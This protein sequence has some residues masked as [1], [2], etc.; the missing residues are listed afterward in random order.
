LP[1]ILARFWPCCRRSPT[2]D[3]VVS[4]IEPTFAATT[5]LRGALTFD[6][7]EGIDRNT[8]L[9]RRFAGG[10][11]K[12]VAARSPRNLGRHTARILIVDEAD[13]CETTPEGNP[14]RLAEKRTLSFPNRKIIIGST[15]LLEETSHVLRSYAASD[16]RIFECPCPS[17][18]AFA[19]LLW[20]AIEWPE[21]R[22]E[23]AAWRCP[24]CAEL[25]AERHK[26][27]MVTAGAWRA[28]REANGHAGF[29]CSA[30]ISL[31]GNASWGRLAEEFLAARGDP[32]ELMTFVNTV[33]GE[34]WSEG[35]C[36]SSKPMSE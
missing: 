17:C 23:A 18:G 3:Y 21:G 11:L 27:G 4:D 13:A 8:L 36:T 14:L 24:S 30:L 20:K 33:L 26:H 35:E 28:T 31:L 29:R 6:S 10:S 19:E 16:M 32:S 2:R 25:I 5:A 34:G 9:H 15:P 1:P 12:V 7:G 22:P